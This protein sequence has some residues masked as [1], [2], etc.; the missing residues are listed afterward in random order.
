MIDRRHLIALVGGAT[1]AW[2]LELPA[3]QPG[4]TYRLG[5]LFNN[6][7]ETPNYVALMDELRRHGFVEG[8]NLTDDPR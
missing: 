4:R 6:A 3:Q 8:Q 7:R 1:L 5:A 2:P